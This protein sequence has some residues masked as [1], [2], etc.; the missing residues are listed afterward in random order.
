MGRVFT[1]DFLFA[2]KEHSAIV[3]MVSGTP[4]T[5]FQIQVMDKSL[6][7]IF[8]SGKINYYGNNGYQQLIADQHGR[9][10]TLLKCIAA[11]IEQHLHP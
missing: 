9:S 8:P 5:A 7:H 11:A 4:D 3:T 1:I 6:H 10:E 2:G